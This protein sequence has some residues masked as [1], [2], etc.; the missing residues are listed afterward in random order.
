M[1][2]A[3]EHFCSLETRGAGDG[4]HCAAE[5]YAPLPAQGS[6][7]VEAQATYGLYAVGTDEGGTGE[8]DL[9]QYWAVWK[10]NLRRGS[11]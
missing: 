3:L 1:P 11:S 5:V 4:Y 8:M 7:A 2:R 6:M 9:L 10:S